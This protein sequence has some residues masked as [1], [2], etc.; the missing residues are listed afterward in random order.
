MAYWKNLL[1]LSPFP[2]Q[3]FFA[4]VD[5]NQTASMN[6]SQVQQLAT[7]QATANMENGVLTSSG[8]AYATAILSPDRSATVSA[9]SFTALVASNSIVSIF[10]PHLANSNA[11]AA[12]MP[13][14]TTLAD[15]T[16][17]ITDNKGTQV[18]APLFYA[19]PTQVNAV[20][21][22]G[23]NPGLIAL[24]VNSPSGGVTSAVKS[25]IVAPA[26]FAAGEDGKGLAAA[27]VQVGNTFTNAVVCSG[28]DMSCTAV[29]INVAGGNTYLVLYGTGIRNQAST[30]DV[31]VQVGS[32][33]LPVSFA[34]A[35][36]GFVGLDQVNVL[37]PNSLAGSG[38]VNVTVNV[39]GTT[40]NAV[41][42][43]IK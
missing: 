3:Y 34:G 37:L 30:S 28:G 19:G 20:I 9:A 15:V 14:P 11:S 33:T 24:T 40:S 22:P 29:P 36:S 16:V 38:N 2:I 6:T 41:T 13:L 25:A 1:Y 27:Q 43:A 35:A 5:Y 10:G 8:Q 4:Y 21:P 31:T 26:L 23:I 42:I 32:Q 18:A 17:T 12:A 39:N 7:T